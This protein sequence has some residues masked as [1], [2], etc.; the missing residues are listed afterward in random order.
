MD[1]AIELCTLPRVA[2]ARAVGGRPTQQDALVCLHDADQ[3][4]YLLVVADGMGGDGAGETASAGVVEVA[5]RLWDARGWT[6]QA[7]TLF[8][9]SLCQ[10]AH[11]ELRRRGEHLAPARP[12]ST[13]V[14]ALLRG[15]R[16]AWAH[17][18]DSRL[19]RF[20]GR[21]LLDRTVD[22]SVAQLKV[23]RGELDPEDLARDPDQHKLLRGLGGDQPPEVEHGC[24][25][26][27]PGQAFAL[28]SD[29]VWEQLSAR[30]LGRFLQRRDLSEGL[31]QAMALVLERGGE[32]GDNA[33]LIFARS[34]GGGRDRRQGRRWWSGLFGGPAHDRDEPIPDPTAE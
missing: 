19:Y 30:E 34:G 3:D 29:G 25:P 31:H 26:L 24:A 13:I 22:H 2:A 32:S 5:R 4:A 27:R 8:L 28:C 15:G 7:A 12:H 6:G 16:I 23:A 9:E 10:Q 18:G 17:V 33:A 21:R 14:A 11:A 1:D 20:D